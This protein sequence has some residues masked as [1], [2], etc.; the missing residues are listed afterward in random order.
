MFKI[1]HLFKALIP[2]ILIIVICNF[3]LKLD[4]SNPLLKRFCVLLG[5]Q[6]IEGGYVQFFTYIAFFLSLELIN[7]K[8]AF[9]GHQ[10]SLNEKTVI[11]KADRPVYLPENVNQIKVKAEESPYKDSIINKVIIR[12]CA[13]FRGTQSTSEMMNMVS[14]QM[15]A[16]SDHEYI[17]QAPI[18]YLNSAIPS[19][20]F[21]GTVIGLSNA[22]KWANS[23]NMNIIT[24]EL[25]VAFDTTLVALVLGLIINWFTSLMEKE[26]DSLFIEIKQIITDKLINRI[27]MTQ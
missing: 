22:M 23:G 19:L 15:Q 27:E 21:I 2:A 10:K 7:E 26:S 14:E 3:G 12:A 16:Y 24:Q 13:K 1:N 20:G 18:R 17:E 11:G 9:I 8:R 25:G 5:G 4:L 6:F